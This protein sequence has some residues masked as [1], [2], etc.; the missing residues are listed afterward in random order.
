MRHTCVICFG[1]YFTDYPHSFAAARSLTAARR[2]LR[3]RGYKARER[4]PLTLAYFENDESQQ[5]ARVVAAPFIG[6]NDAAH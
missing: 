6:E 3:A 5:W 1:A 4:R 2:R